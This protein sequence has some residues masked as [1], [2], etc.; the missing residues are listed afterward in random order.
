[1]SLLA[2]LLLLTGAHGGQLEPSKLQQ[3]S[4]PAGWDKIIERDPHYVVFG[5]LHGTEQAPAFVGRL[6]CYLASKGQRILV[7]VELSAADDQELQDAWKL[8]VTLFEKSLSEIGWRGRNDGVASEAMFAMLVRLHNLNAQGFPIDVVA[9]NAPRDD[10]QPER[11]AD[12]PGQ[13]PH[14]AEQADNIA[15]ASNISEYDRVLV[16]V[17]NIHALKTS[18]AWRGVQFDPMAKRLALYGSTLSLDMRYAEGTS[19]NCVLKHSATPDDQPVT[20]DALDCGNH[21]TRGSEDLG[22]DPFIE[23]VT[24]T[25]ESQVADYDGFFWVGQVSGSPPAVVD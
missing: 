9:F 23:L 16:L 10:K 2:S 3:C 18:V 6:A 1:M 20:D 21:A 17:G 24:T 11:F 13:G 25:G 14:D 22:P 12:L 7:A 15:Q 4:E 19:W 5:E 8:P